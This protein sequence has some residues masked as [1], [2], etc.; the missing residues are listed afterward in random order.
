MSTR[1][2]IGRT[3]HAR[4]RRCSQLGLGP[5]LTPLIT[6]PIY[7]LHRSGSSMLTLIRSRPGGFAVP[8]NE[9]MKSRLS[10]RSRPAAS[11]RA[12][13]RCPMQSGRLDVT[14][15]SMTAWLGVTE[16]VWGLGVLGL[17]GHLAHR[18][19]RRVEERQRPDLE[20]QPGDPLRR[21]FG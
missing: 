7:L 9:G 3:P 10:G 6:P 13:P 16:V 14:S 11:S 12:T 20:A 19:L 4:S 5:T 2:L 21:V 17:V 1:L 15:I 8:V 18:V